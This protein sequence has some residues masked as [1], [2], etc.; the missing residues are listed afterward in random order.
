MREGFEVAAVAR[1]DE[2]IVEPM[3]GETANVVFDYVE[4]RRLAQR[5]RSGKRHVVRG[6]SER[7][8]GRHHCRPDPCGDGK[9]SGSADQGV[10]GQRQ[11]RAVLFGRSHREDDVAD[12]V[13]HRL[14]HL[15]PRHLRHREGCAERRAHQAVTAV[16]AASRLAFRRLSIASAAIFPIA[17]STLLLRM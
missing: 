3:S 1:D 6:N 5:D 16:A 17:A 9:R 14:L 8:G 13:V 10:R 2:D 4:K 7:D 15:G 11:V 12:P